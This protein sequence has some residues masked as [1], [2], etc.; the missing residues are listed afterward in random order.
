MQ[1]S[2]ENPRI[3]SHNHHYVLRKQQE[4]SFSPHPHGNYASSAVWSLKNRDRS[5]YRNTV[6]LLCGPA[7]ET[8]H[9][10]AV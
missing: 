7:Y 4:R 3:T 5:C 1:D 10:P 8:L 2:K 6:S 9:V